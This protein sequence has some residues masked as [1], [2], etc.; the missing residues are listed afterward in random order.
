MKKIALAALLCFTTSASATDNWVEAKVL[1]R[2][3]IMSAVCS[4]SYNFAQDIDDDLAKIGAKC[5]NQTAKQYNKTFEW[6][7]EE[8]SKIDYSK[9]KGKV[10]R[11]ECLTLTLALDENQNK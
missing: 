1:N 5:I 8:Y 2:C 9:F 7:V 10:S 4:I 6:I 3:I 11:G